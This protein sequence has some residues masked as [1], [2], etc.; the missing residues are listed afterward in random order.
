MYW[1][2]IDLFCDTLLVYK[3]IE[4]SSVALNWLATS[5]SKNLYAILRLE[6]TLGFDWIWFFGDLKF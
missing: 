4:F 6:E 1:A 5:A 2:L 3:T